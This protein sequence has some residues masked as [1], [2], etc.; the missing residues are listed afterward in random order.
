[1]TAVAQIVADYGPLAGL[2]GVT[3]T[4]AVNGYRDERQRRRDNHARAIEAVVAY[5]EMSYRIRR[6]RNEPDQAS[7][8]RTRL[9]DAFS[10][11]QA[12]LASC[13]AT[14]RADPDP[15]IR[16]AYERLV[17]A[18]RQNAGLLVRDAWS[19]TPVADDGAM[20][21]P[22]VHDA[23]A[24]VRTEQTKCEAVMAAST[25]GW[26]RVRRFQARGQQGRSKP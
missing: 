10:E 19:M 2:A 4:L 24:P 9:S 3:A 18:L 8:E 15:H 11:I 13:E 21:M 20:N 12:E 7:S 22:D 6:R 17:T 25:R 16:V 14:I 1:M 26:R 5:S 23:L